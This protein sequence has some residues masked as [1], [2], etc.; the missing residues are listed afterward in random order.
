MDVKILFF[1]D[2]FSELFRKVHDENELVWDD[3]WVAS[4]EKALVDPN[5][6]LG[7]TFT[8]IKTGEIE[9][10]KKIVEKEQPDIVIMDYYWPEHALK[11]YGDRKKG[12]EI[13]L[14]TLSQMRK[15]FPNLPM[16]SYTIK[17][18][19]QTMEAA[20]NN[21]VTLFMEKVA[22]AVPEVHNTL[23]YIIIYMMRSK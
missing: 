23:K 5:N 20:Y 15:A 1:D 16:I 14:E 4:L 3:N 11:K 8:L 9:A 13:S 18:D 10:W 22:M 21:G 12:G 17:P 6:R 7:V 2:I 19:Q